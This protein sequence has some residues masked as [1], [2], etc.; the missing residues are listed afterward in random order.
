MRNLVIGLALGAA[1]G[2]ASATLL[3]QRSADTYPD[4]VTA[5]PK[6]YSVSF[7]NDVV[8]FIRAKYGPGEKSVMHRH[9]PGCVI[10]L[11]DQTMNFTIPDGTTEPASV[12]AGAL[13]CSDGNV[14]QPENSDQEAE[15]IMV[16]FKDR[17]TFL[18]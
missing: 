14:H 7:E 3:A 12:P 9:L 17:K 13:G 8:R 11:T 2:G 6:H 5:D 18:K 15:F 4:A 10:F 1:L 16:E